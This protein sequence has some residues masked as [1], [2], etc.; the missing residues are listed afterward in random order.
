MSSMTTVVV[1]T[2]LV[3]VV[4]SSEVALTSS[5]VTSAT[6][7]VGDGSGASVAVGDVDELEQPTLLSAPASTTPNV[8]K[9]RWGRFKP[10]IF[11][12]RCS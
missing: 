9:E 5:E 4:G 12:A 3:V 1:V 6:V 2:S 8:I 11:S 7:V 10:T